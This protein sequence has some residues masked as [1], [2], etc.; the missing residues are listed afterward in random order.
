MKSRVSLRRPTEMIRFLHQLIEWHGLFSEPAD[1]PTQ[2]GQTRSKLLDI[3]HSLR[4]FHSFNRTDFLRV[5]LYPSA[6]NQE[7]EQLASWHTESA[8]GRIE[9][10]SEPSKIRECFLKVIEQ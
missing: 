9:L 8:L 2:G 6:R 3:F 1:K 10:D 5:G 7:T 4:K